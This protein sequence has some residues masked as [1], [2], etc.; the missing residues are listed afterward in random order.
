MYS[1]D[2]AI[3]LLRTE[4]PRLTGKF[5]FSYRYRLPMTDHEVNGVVQGHDEAAVFLK[6]LERYK[7]DRIDIRL[8]LF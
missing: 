2:D 3:K 1:G 5:T 6:H 8:T 7:P 4:L